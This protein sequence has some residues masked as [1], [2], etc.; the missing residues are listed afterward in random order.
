MGFEVDRDQKDAA[1]LRSALR[2][3]AEAAAIRDD[4]DAGESTRRAGGL[5]ERDFLLPRLSVGQ[6]QGEVAVEVEAAVNS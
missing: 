2:G 5:G 6:A 1:P 4:G 3:G